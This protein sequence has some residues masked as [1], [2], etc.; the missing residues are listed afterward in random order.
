VARAGKEET[1]TR[2]NPFVTTTRPR[3]KEE[4]EVQLAPE[5]PDVSIALWTIDMS[6]ERVCALDR[7]VI[8]PP[9]N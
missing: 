3:R 8:A 1:A 5:L 6:R 9:P 4:R 2:M 7:S